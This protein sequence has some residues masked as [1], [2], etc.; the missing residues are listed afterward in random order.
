MQEVLQSA[1]KKL[2]LSGMLQ[3]LDIR[4]QEATG[5]RLSHAEFLEIIL[6][7]ELLIR[8]ERQIQRGVKACGF[9]ELK[10][11]EDF[12]FSFNPTVPK[13]QIFDLAGGTFIHQH[14]DVLFLGPPGTGK[15]H[16]VQAIG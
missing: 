1:L 4:L 10:T 9:R 5:N 11:L 2:R 16:L 6:Q 8:N 14:K 3:T 13:K 7:D 15:S 12:D